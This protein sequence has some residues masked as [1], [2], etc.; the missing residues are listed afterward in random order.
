MMECWNDLLADAISNVKLKGEWVDN[1]IGSYE[2]WGAPGYHTQEEFEV[3]GGSE[4][5]IEWTEEAEEPQEPLSLHI[6]GTSSVACGPETDIDVEV[7]AVLQSA[8]VTVQR[9][10]TYLWKATYLVG[11]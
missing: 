6:T 7:E 4:V 9:D 1:G 3:T 2:Y 10:G 5:T 11:E 8:T